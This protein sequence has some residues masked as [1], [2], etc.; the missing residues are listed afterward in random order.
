MAPTT[1]PGR[2]TPVGASLPTLLDDTPPLSGAVDR[3]LP[4]TPDSN[5]A[6][7][8][9]STS[10]SSRLSQPATEDELQTVSQ[11][12]TFFQRAREHRR[13]L[14]AQWNKNYRVL[15]NR[16][17]LDGRAAWLP[18]PEVPEIY[19]ILASMVG[20][21]TDQRPTLDVSPT[22]EPHSSYHEFFSTIAHDLQT[23]M[24]ASLRDQQFEAQAELSMWDSMIY[25]T[26]ILKTCWDGTRVGGLGDAIIRRI[27]PYT[28]Y[29]DPFATDMDDAGYFIEARNMSLQELDRRWPGSSDHISAGIQHDIDKA[30]D[31]MDGHT[32]Q[33]RAQPGA[34]HG[35]TRSSYGAPGG[36]RAHA[37]EDQGVTVLE[38]WL[39]DHEY[40]DLPHSG[41]QSVKDC[42]RVVVIAGNRVIMDEKADDIWGHGTHPYDK[43][44]P[45]A[46]G[47][48]WGF[49]MVEWLVPSQIAINSLLAS[50]MHNINLTGNPVFME[51]QRA[52]ISRTKITN[53]PGQR[54]ATNDPDRS[55]WMDVPTLPG[56]VMTLIEFFV[57]EME[58]ISGLSAI[59]RGMMSGGRPAA[60]VV[61]SMQEASFVRVRQAVR[62]FERALGSAGNK[63]ASLMVENYTESRVVQVTGPQ[64]QKSALALRGYHFYTP[65]PE[66]RLPMK[67][68]LN[69]EAGST[70]ATSRSAR[71]AEADTLFAMGALD[72]EAV[73][74]AHNYPNRAVIA[75]RI[76][77]AMAAGTFQPPGARERSG[78]SS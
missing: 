75:K 64:A 3:A 65:T 1:L 4:R 49:S 50:A 37:V 73:L 14:V 56:H 31:N 30:P 67:F 52:G 32:T 51:S 8:D 9:D 13:P 18:R 10:R 11:C 26:G 61:E 28:F 27:D 77:D 21:M 68:N 43:H 39:R 7:G 54:I 44:T 23:A 34:M 62:G 33:A 41:E 42:W 58:R 47:Q 48:F 16:T 19:P 59:T 70:L 2:P 71:I 76:Q 53:K 15:C 29:P 57:N 45:H 72:H 66:G 35:S 17:W 55:K 63:M 25:G 20:W 22:S 40:I 38:C 60:G 6:W 36:G 5:P 46:N 24:Q 74:E 78:R 12:T 69:I